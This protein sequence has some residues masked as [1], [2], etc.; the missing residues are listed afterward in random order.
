MTVTVTFKEISNIIDDTNKGTDIACEQY[1]LLL[2]HN[3]TCTTRKTNANLSTR[4]YQQGNK[5]QCKLLK[6]K[7]S[8]SFEKHRR[9]RQ[10][11][12]KALMK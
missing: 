9:R 1:T 12:D 2:S 6:R 3:T 7:E 11:F 4:S 8:R 5:G 10:D